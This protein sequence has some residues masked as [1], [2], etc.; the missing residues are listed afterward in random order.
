MAVS[1]IHKEHKWLV[2]GSLVIIAAVALGL[3]L[4]Y[5]RSV[6]IPFVLAVFIFV[7][8]SPILDFQVLRL[9]IPRALAV[10]VTLLIVLIIL[11][12]ICLFLSQAIQTVVD[13]AGRYSDSFVSLIKQASAKM[14]QWG[15][16]LEPAEI[17]GDLQRQI[18]ALVTNTVGTVFGFLSS[19]FLVA[20]FVIFL[21]I[22]RN[23]H[24][25]HVGIYGDIDQKIRR[26]LATKAVISTVTG[27][28]VWA[29]L[30]LFKLELAG[31]FGMLAFLLNFIPSIGSVFATLLPLPIAVAQFQEPWLI[32]AIVLVPGTIQMVIGNGIEPKL[33]GEGM[34]LNPVVIL[35]AL[36][37][38]GILWGVVGMFLAVP[39]TA[40]IRIV[41]MQF[42]TLKPIGNLLAGQLPAP[43]TKTPSRPTRS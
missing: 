32:V 18:P 2:T 28:L 17:T 20:I 11:T 31:V 21:L 25:V 39:M 42:D 1:D 24:A 38:W 23:P 37:F 10:V 27:L 5:A 14:Q 3:T 15:I 7:L 41:L 16:V 30:A 12:A 43:K 40:V 4:A 19:V 34:H 6:L 9:K 8:V 29:V 22:G 33:L 26:Y 35:L 13:T 36:S